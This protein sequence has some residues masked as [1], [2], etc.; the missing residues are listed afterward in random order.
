M[1]ERG[2]SWEIWRKPRR[3]EH[4]KPHA[5]DKRYPTLM[6]HLLLLLLSAPYTSFDHFAAWPIGQRRSGAA[7]RPLNRLRCSK[8]PAENQFDH[9]MIRP[10]GQSGPDTRFYADPFSVDIDDGKYLMRLLGGG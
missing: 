9:A 7:R 2:V 4:W 10:A 8:I 3:T 5:P 1:K 6:V